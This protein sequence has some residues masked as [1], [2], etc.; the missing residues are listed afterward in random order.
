M[1]KIIA[2]VLIISGI[3][4]AS[5]TGK[6]KAMD[7]PYDLQL[8][9]KQTE[10]NK[11]IL[12]ASMELDSGSYFGSPL[13]NNNFTGLFT[14]SFEENHHLTMEDTIIEIPRSKEVIDYF[15]NT[16]GKIKGEFVVMF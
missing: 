2:L 11:F 3:G 8:Q 16:P 14:I 10:N 5:I 13:S 15:E 1:N 12:V 9:I 6:P 7:D 4:Y